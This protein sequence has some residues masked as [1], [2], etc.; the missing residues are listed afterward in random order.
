MFGNTVTCWFLGY[1][2]ISPIHFNCRITRNVHITNASH[3]AQQRI[4]SLS[5]DFSHFA[6]AIKELRN[7]LPYMNFHVYGTAELDSSGRPL[8]FAL[9]IFVSECTPTRTVFNEQNGQVIPFEEV[10]Y[11]WTEANT[12]SDDSKGKIFFLTCTGSY[13]HP[14]YIITPSDLFKEAQKDKTKKL[15]CDTYLEAIDRPLS[16]R[17]K[18]NFLRHISIITC[19]AM[20]QQ[21]KIGVRVRSIVHSSADSK[22][23]THELVLYSVDK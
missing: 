15:A 9:G 8:D 3:E 20:D 5:L 6:D 19:R 11:D 16:G 14:L 13:S 12:D 4:K 18:G 10:G 1:T 23:M 7:E 21:K 17:G 22:S 2:L